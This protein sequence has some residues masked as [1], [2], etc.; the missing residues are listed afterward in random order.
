MTPDFKV[1]VIEV[2]H[3]MNQ[4]GLPKAFI[5]DAVSTA[6][7][8]EGIFDLLKMWAVEVNAKERNEIVLDIQELIKDCQVKVATSGQSRV[9]SSPIN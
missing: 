3:Q 6:F 2:G 7:E 8:F 1:E 4:A 5:A 9:Q